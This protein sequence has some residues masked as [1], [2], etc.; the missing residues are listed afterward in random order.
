MWI[1][2]TAKIISINLVHIGVNPQLLN[3]LQESEPSSIYSMAMIGNYLVIIK[4]KWDV[5]LTL[6]N[7]GHLCPGFRSNNCI[8]S[9]NNLNFSDLFTT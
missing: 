3:I 5:P 8:Q 4:Q 9:I 1:I 7:P 6:K 2:S